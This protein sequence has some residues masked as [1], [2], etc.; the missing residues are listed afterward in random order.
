VGV[1]ASDELTVDMHVRDPQGHLATVRAVLATGAPSICRVVL[2]DSD[3]YRHDIVC[4][5]K[6]RWVVV[7]CP[8]SLIVHDDGTVAGCT[9]DRERDGC[10]GRDELHDGSPVR[11]IKWF[12][13]GCDYCGVHN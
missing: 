4:S 11:C 3:G 7:S 6:Q 10:R 5:R 2:T 12:E 8:G 1:V 9:E 13:C